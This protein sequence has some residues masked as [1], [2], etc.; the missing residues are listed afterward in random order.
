[1]G[2]K[3]LR[4]TGMDLIGNTS[5]GTHFC[6]FYQT[7]EDLI[8]I[9]VPYFKAGLENN[10]FCM[11]ITAEPLNAK[12]A[13]ASL[14]KVVR[15]LDDS[16]EKGQ[17]EI[18][19]FSQWYTKSGK[20]DADEVLDGWVE[21]EKQALEKG[22]DGLRLTGNTFWLEDEDW[23][24]FTEYEETINNIIKNY[25]MIAV[26]SYSLDKCGATKIMDV[27]A[28][29]QFALVK[30]EN[31]WEI[32]ESSERKQEALRESEENFRELAEKSPLGV[33]IADEKANHLYVNKRFAEIT[34]YSIDELIG[35][36]G[37]EVLTRPEDKR[38]YIERMEKRMK[39]EPHKEQYERV[40]LRKD[41]T[42][43]LTEFFTTKTKWKGEMCPMVIVQDITERKQTE[44]AL[45]TSQE[46]SRNVID[47]SMDMI[48]TSNKDR[49]IVEF[50]KAAE[51]TF[52]YG[53]EEVIGKLA[54][55]LYADPQE[56]LAVHKTTVEQ[57]KCAQEIL[58]KRKS[59]EAFPSFL[60]AS[61]L[62][63]AHGEVMGVMGVSRDIT[64]HKQSEEMLLESEAQKQALLDGSPD[65]I[66]Q[67]DTDMRI[68]WAN[69]SAIDMS[70]DIL[71][72]TCYK[73]FANKDD[74]CEDCPCKR[75]M[76]TGKIERGV[77][78][79][80]V[81]KG[82]QGESYWENIGVPIKDSADRI[83]GAI[84]IKRNVT[85]RIEVE[86]ALQRTLDELEERV[87][88]R[89]FE[90]QEVNKELNEKR[91][92]LDEINAALRVLLQKRDQDKRELE[93]KVL[94]NIKE[95]VEPHLKKLKE[96]GLNES[97]NT[98]LSI[99][100]SNLGNIISPFSR[101][102]SSRYVNLTP[103]E[104]QVADLVKQGQ[105]TKEIAKHLYSSTSAVNFHRNNIRKKL[106]LKNEKIN[107]RSYLLSLR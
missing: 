98:Y 40:L 10:E 41:G 66:L 86:Q 107:L 94:S 91:A 43:I 84:E 1:M 39:G 72:Q 64:T 33:V 83:T 101:T 104:I 76:S 75:C 70:N 24:D 93:D 106:G 67:I 38:K 30:R 59:G 53:R 105:P 45:R 81:I 52:G 69:K 46:Y 103:S 14:K 6:Q 79:Y 23:R 32:V 15:N 34:G 71:G 13:K 42:A 58:N 78:H 28:N 29:H 22:F 74:S 25:K 36:N 56:G 89:T 16:I 4:E 7:P 35:M 21:K 68:L 5:W 92:N 65:L 100:E 2:K 99:L 17:I 73:G 95:L 11:W 47:S 57:G 61:L 9:L 19:D 90:L 54:D 63:D 48:I 26:C 50:N 37:F 82:I 51:K 20:F 87:T 88:E 55:I 49:N 18:L 60:S 27:V 44:E 102:L 77:M 97:Q 12:K 3:E 31:R 96:S 62:R 80:P 8:D 85:K